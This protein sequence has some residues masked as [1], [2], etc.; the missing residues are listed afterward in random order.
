MFRY[1]AHPFRLLT[2][3]VSWSTS[4]CGRSLP[5]LP[6]LGFVVPEEL[7]ALGTDSFYHDISLEQLE[8]LEQ[9][10]VLWEPAVLELLPEVESNSIYQNLNV[11]KGVGALLILLLVVVT[12]AWSPDTP[13][14]DTGG[15]EITHAMGS[16]VVPADPQRVVVLDTAG[17]LRSPNTWAASACMP[18]STCW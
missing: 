12:A 10:V 9:D 8:L 11:A 1:R 18:G 3:R 4:F 5:R 13:S 14:G 2:A 7:T 15:R 6:N 16:T 17:A